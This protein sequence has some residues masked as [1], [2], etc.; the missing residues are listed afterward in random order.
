MGRRL[1]SQCILYRLTNEVTTDPLSLVASINEEHGNVLTMCEV[2]HAYGG[3]L[4]SPAR[5]HTLAAAELL[6]PFTH[7]FCYRPENANIL[8]YRYCT[9]NVIPINGKDANTSNS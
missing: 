5:S 7:K 3:D 2:E 9:R 1:L 4:D 8:L 6:D